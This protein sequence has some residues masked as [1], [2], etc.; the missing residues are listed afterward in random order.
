MGNGFIWMILGCMYIFPFVLNI[1]TRT[2]CFYLEM[3]LFFFFFL[4]YIIEC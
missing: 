2:V 4:W 3:H 1:D